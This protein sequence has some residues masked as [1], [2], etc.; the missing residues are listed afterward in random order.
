MGKFLLNVFACFILSYFV[1]NILSIISSI[2]GNSLFLT[3]LVITII[4]M[5]V[6]KFI[7]YVIDTEDRVRVLEKKLAEMKENLEKVD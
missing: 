4:L 3:L 5:V 2:V 1:L 6:G 7:S